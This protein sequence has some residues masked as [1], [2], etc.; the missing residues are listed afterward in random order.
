MQEKLF[1][2]T[3][4]SRKGRVWRYDVEAPN[5]RGARYKAAAVKR[6]NS[7]TGKTE[8]T[9]SLIPYAES[10]SMDGI[11]P[12]SSSDLPASRVIPIRSKI[13]C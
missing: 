7:Y 2:V 5:K 12:L 3:V 6:H 1:H 13:S 8:I 10:L 4:T 11:K 9:E